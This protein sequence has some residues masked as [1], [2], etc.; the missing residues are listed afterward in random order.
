MDSIAEALPAGRDVLFEGSPG[1]GKTL[2]ALAPALAFG[3]REDK[4]V[5]I[6][7]NVHQ[8]TRQ[9]VREA[10]AITGE[11]P[12]RAV[13]FRG[14]ES[15]CHID[16][17]YRECQAL[18]D[19]TRD[20]VD[21]ERDRAEIQGQL[22]EL[23]G[24]GRTDPD[25]PAAGARAEAADRLEE[26]ESTLGELRDGGTCDY[27][28]RNLTA[29]GAVEEFYG[30]LHGD[31]RTPDEIYTRAGQA[32]LCGYELLKD[33]MAEVDLVV[34][35]YHHLLDPTIREQFFRWL[36]RDPEDVIAVFDEAHNVESAARD[37]ATRTLSER[38]LE[39]AVDELDGL[40]DPRAD[41]A[42]NAVG[43]FRDALV[44]TYEEGLGFGDVGEEWTDVPVAGGEGKDDLTMAFLRRYEGRGIEGDLSAAEDLGEDLDE[45]YERAFRR[46]ETDTR[47]ESDTLA[48]ARFLSEW[49]DAADDRGRHPVASVRRDAGT[50]EVY[51]RAELYTA[52]PRE[53]TSDLF[54]ELYASVLM[55]AT[56]RPFEVTAD[57]LGLDDPATMAFGMTFP[58]RNRHTLAV[59]TPALFASERGDPGVQR[60]VADALADTVRFTP[61][62]TLVFF[63]SYGEADRYAGLLEDRVD[64]TLY[65]DRA[66]VRA[67]DL[68]EEFAAGDDGVLL[69]SLWGTL[70]EGVSFDGDDA[71]T[72][73][74]VGVPYPRLDDRTEAVQDAY[75]AATGGDGWEYAVEIP[76][77]RKTR[78]ALGRVVRG[79]EEVGARVLL[80]ER[81]TERAT[82]EMGDYAVR[83]TFPPEERAEL[84]DVD[85][86]N[87]G[88]S[89]RN[90]YADH[91]AYGGDP[92][93]IE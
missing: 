8:Q 11:E 30:W 61:G 59:A 39:G 69:T 83:S 60:T 74:V 70:A 29:Q 80:D 32:G 57:V 51:G 85:P 40:E 76:T 3:A 1:T 27:Y 88:V 55:S 63:P 90:F 56:L 71:H 50:D 23:D 31:V 42:R 26:V 48:A 16:V 44:A 36:D 92:P 35:N 46:G 22:D 6:T 17:G 38:T 2:S 45:R 9:F 47:R 24:A 62:N 20:L 21:A 78:Q 53:V 66:G 49:M 73:A 7:T 67:E 91:D 4:T 10:S 81:Y 43:A 79:P 89:L 12:I 37:H 54:G 82:V 28:Y 15:M 68:R 18:R 87:L 13:V 58:E 19:A 34:C 65:R 84:V 25:D 41:R 33:G 86:A 64:A 93:P 77:I 5:V 14:K 52:I 75:D 72:V